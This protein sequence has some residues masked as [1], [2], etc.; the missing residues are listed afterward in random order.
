[1]PTNKQRRRVLLAGAGAALAAAAGPSLA[2]AITARIVVGFP[3]GGTAD[4][5]ARVLAPLL[6]SPD[7]NFIVEN[8]PGATGQLAAD[9]VR[10]AAVGTLSMLLTP[11]SVLSLAP[12]LYRK[13]LFDGVADFAPVGCVCD[14]SFGFAVPGNSPHA[15]LADY[16]A[17]AKANPK[18]T[19]YATPGA[20]SA[21]HFLGAMFAR[22]IDVPLIH[23]P[24]RGVMPGVQDLVGGQV[25]ATFNPL[26][27]LLEFHKAG[28]I[29]ILAVTNPA[30]V[31]SLPQTPTFTELKYPALELM[32]WYGVFAPA[33]LGAPALAALQKRL[34]HALAQPAMAEA[35]RRLEVSL[36]LL[37]AAEQRKLLESDHRRWKTTVQTTGIQL[38]S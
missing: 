35:A 11:S 6:S 14:H 18:A 4:S 38:E 29:R 32:E 24:Y 22:E 2:Q 20:G 36:R 17:W 10:T 5:L 7:L 12:Q 27:S 23:V 37:S 16:M 3:A 30:R 31:A 25:S 9:S 19:T 34:A 33:R 15:T 21:P 13:P 8:K 26:T 28:R 1:M